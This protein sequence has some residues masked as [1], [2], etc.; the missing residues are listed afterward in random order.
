MKTLT[1]SL[2]FLLTILQIKAE[3][4]GVFKS[5]I[6]FSITKRYLD[7]GLASE[8]STLK[9]TAFE[10]S[11]KISELFRFGYNDHEL[12]VKSN[13]D[14]QFSQ[15]L[16]SG[17]YV[18]YFYV[19]GYLEIITDTIEIKSQEVIEAEL[20]LQNYE[21]RLSDQPSTKNHCPDL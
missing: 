11:K 6:P 13:K 9:I 5:Q 4:R 2:L 16:K 21:S 19:D 18:L 20:H 17:K 10:G 14:G 1:L 8:K 7:A 3:E 15:N 12:A